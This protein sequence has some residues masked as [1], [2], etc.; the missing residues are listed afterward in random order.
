MPSSQHNWSNSW[1]LLGTRSLL[2][3]KRSMNSLPLSVICLGNNESA[4][5]PKSGHIRRSNAWVRCLLCEFVHAVARTRCA[6]KAK[7]DS[8]AIRKGHKNSVVAL[9]HKMLRIV[10]A[11]LATGSQYQDKPIDHEAL[12]VAR[13]AR[14]GS[15]CCANTASRQTM[16]PDRLAICGLRAP[17]GVGSGLGTHGWLCLPH[18][19][20]KTN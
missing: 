5:K 1:L 4:G 6:L 11:R 3:N 8:L 12:S 9:A 2:A 16:P 19:D 20:T 15:R 13:N 7:F 17:A 18:L 14:A 10:Y